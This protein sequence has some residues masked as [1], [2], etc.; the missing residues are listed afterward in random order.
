MKKIIVSSLC[1]LMAVSSMNCKAEKNRSLIQ[2]ET[3]GLL[4]KALM[5]ASGEDKIIDGVEYAAF[6]RDLGYTKP[7]TSKT[8]IKLNVAADEAGEVEFKIWLYGNKRFPNALDVDTFRVSQKELK[9]Y[10]QNH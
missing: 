5:K 6:I 10:L 9:Q 2:Q 1:A 7:Y 3:Q 8:V 4:D